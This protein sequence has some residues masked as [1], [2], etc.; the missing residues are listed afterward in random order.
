MP[1]SLI[2]VFLD[3]NILKTTTSDNLKNSHGVDFELQKTG[4]SF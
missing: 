4:A 3:V 2:S 1:L